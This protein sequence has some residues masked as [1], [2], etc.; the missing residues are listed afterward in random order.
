MRLKA[1]GKYLR[2]VFLTGITK[3][4]Q[5]SIFSELNNIENISMD[6]NYAAICGI[7]EEEMRTQMDA[8]IALFADK[9]GTTKE[10]ALQQLKSYYDG[11][12]FAW[13][14]P[15]IYNPFSLVGALS[16]GRIIPFW[17]G[18]GTPTYL[19]EMLNKF[20]V[21]P[22]EIS[23][24]K[25]IADD[26]NTPIELMT[27]ITPLLYQ[28]GFLTIKGYSAFSRLYQLD[29]P[30]KEVRIRLMEMWASHRESRHQLR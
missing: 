25:R 26:F 9:L 1:C 6:A 21:I 27:D 13:P 28:S 8:D 17:F 20:Q 14:S 12:H 15:D 23:G 22:L 10:D 11:Y 3:F 5:L 18:S 4:S 24:G 19:I 30:N 2:Y 16:E 7:T 29:V